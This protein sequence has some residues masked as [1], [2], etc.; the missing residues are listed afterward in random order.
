M[1]A[2]DEW[3]DTLVIV[4][5]DH[6]ELHGEHDLYGHEFGVYDPIVNVPLMVKHP[7]LEPGRYDEQVELVDLYHTVLD[8]AGV[9][10]SD[11]TRPLEEARSLLRGLPSF[12]DDG[13]ATAS[14][15]SWST[16]DRWSN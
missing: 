14:A 9:S 6:G 16:T 2:N 12:A 13:P 7:D 10:G 1:R 11:S 15:P 4:C 8:H 5:A 3:E